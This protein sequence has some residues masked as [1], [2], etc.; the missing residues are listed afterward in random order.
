MTELAFLY[1][2]HFCLF[3]LLQRKIDGLTEYT[4][5]SRVT[6]IVAAGA[7]GARMH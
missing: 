3:S 7:T 6:N 4:V 1:D 2:F 5:I